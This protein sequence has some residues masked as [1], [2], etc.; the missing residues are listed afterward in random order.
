MVGDFASCYFTEKMRL[1]VMKQ[2]MENS[3]CWENLKDFKWDNSEMIEEIDYDYGDWNWH[4]E[5]DRQ[6]VRYTPPGTNQRDD[7]CIITVKFPLLAYLDG[8]GTDETFVVT[9]NN[10]DAF[11][12]YV[13]DQVKRLELFAEKPQLRI[14]YHP[15]SGRTCLFFTDMRNKRILALKFICDSPPNGPRRQGV[16]LK[17]WAEDFWS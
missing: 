14:D 15:D 8:R 11:V 6:V 7:Y 4:G 1:D 12:S 17:Y 16:T 2:M 5:I 9:D 10:T 3:H 13:T